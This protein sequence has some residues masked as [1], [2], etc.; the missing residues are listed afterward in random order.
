[1]SSGEL[2][3]TIPFTYLM[4]SPS[5]FDGDKRVLICYYTRTGLTARVVN[6]VGPR[7]HADLY[8][9]EGEVSY[10]GCCGALR[11]ACHSLCQSSERVVSQLPAT[12]EYDV[13]IIACPIWNFKAPPVVSTFV[14][15][16]DFRGKP[17][18]PLSTCNSKARG[19]LDDFAQLVTTGRFIAKEGF[20]DVKNQTDD[21]LAQ[22]V[23]EW[24]A[25]L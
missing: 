18:I 13:F 5:V 23:T 15:T 12:G 3:F 14:Q 9:I 6:M 16:C 7:V 1:L 11:S 8:E 22:K 4:T 20:Y 10:M 25:G 21:A 19:F 2:I 24:L 17:V